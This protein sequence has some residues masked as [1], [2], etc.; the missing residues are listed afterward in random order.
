MVARAIVGEHLGEIM[1]AVF[2]AIGL[3]LISGGIAQAQE[4]QWWP[5]AIE[6]TATGID[7][8]SKTRSGDVATI[9]FI[10]VYDE[11]NVSENDADY[12]L[13]RFEFSC[14]RRTGAQ[15]SSS[16]YTVGG[17]Y[18]GGYEGRAETISVAPGTVLA[19]AFTAACDRDFAYD[20]EQ[21]RDTDEFVRLTRQVI[22]ENTDYD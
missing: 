11:P 1:K 18:V 17:Q 9:W 10:I 8:G 3:M 15:I 20:P 16:G 4:A 21:V 19:S 7:V 14:S 2:G 22:R 5:L 12:R 6:S 13:S